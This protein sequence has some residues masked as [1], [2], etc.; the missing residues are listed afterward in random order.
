MFCTN[1]G[2]ALYEGAAF[3][4]ACGQPVSGGMP[5]ALPRKVAYAGFWLRAVAAIIDSLVLA[6]PTFV[7]VVFAVAFL[8]VQLPPP[9]AIEN[10]ALPPMRF[11]LPMEGAFVTVHWLY[12]ALMESSGWQGTL[13]K[14]ALGIGVADMQGKRVS[15]GRA[16]GR[17]FG[18]IISGL[19]LFVGYVLA[20]FTERKQALHD[21]LA[22]CIVVKMP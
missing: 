13:G 10:G 8:G 3:C 7:I 14:R 2:V 15:F 17:F 19:T 20:G 22:N 16:S 18:K 6:I 1:C 12:F 5:Q 11:F 9:E 4:S 21:I